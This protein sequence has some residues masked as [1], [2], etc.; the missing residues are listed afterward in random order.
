L[1]QAREPDDQQ[2]AYE[3]LL[4]AERRCTHVTHGWLAS[5]LELESVGEPQMVLS[6]DVD[7][8][9]EEQS[10]GF[11]TSCL[12]A[13]AALKLLQLGHTAVVLNTARSIVDV[14]ERVAQFR[15]MGGVAAFGAATWDGVFGREEDLLPPEGRAQ[16]ARLRDHLAD[17]ESV[18]MDSGYRHCVRASRLVD[19]E[20]TALSG[21]TARQLL[22]DLSLPNLSFWVAPRYTDF[23]DRTVDKAGGLAS[24]QRELGLDSLP[25]AAIGDSGCDVPMLRAARF[26]FAP[27]ETLRGYTPPRGQR[28]V[29]SRHS[30]AQALWD[31]AC[32][33]VPASGLQRDV[34]AIV[35]ELTMPPWL[36]AGLGEPPTG[37]SGLRPRLA[38]FSASVIGRKE[39]PRASEAKEDLKLGTT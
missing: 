18:V 27:A 39:Q 4:E 10:L 32:Q 16:L 38:A 3:L 28:F 17:D 20:L 24:L 23:V 31:A 8:I 21:S 25:I 14:R 2:S 36:P 33:L 30:G 11:S 22:T 26:A 5:A 1:R 19:G 29:R 12:T 9:L 37:R 34:R 35:S 6:L 7:G 15:L 13:V